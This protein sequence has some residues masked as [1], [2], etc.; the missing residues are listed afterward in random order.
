MKQRDLPLGLVDNKIEKCFYF[1]RNRNGSRNPKYFS[2][3]RGR[4]Y[5]AV[6]AEAIAY[7][8]AMNEKF[9]PPPPTSP[10]GRMTRKNT[11]GVVG[12]RLSL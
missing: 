3:R 4:S 12:V 7:A 8:L 6:H 10:K 5:D 2:Y 9:G 1:R 11:S